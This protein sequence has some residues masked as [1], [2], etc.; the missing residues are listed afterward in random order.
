MFLPRCLGSVT[1]VSERVE[2][3]RHFIKIV[4]L[5]PLVDVKPRDRLDSH[6][7]N[8][9]D[10]AD[11]PDRRLEQIVR[12]IAHNNGAIAVE[13][14]E[15]YDGAADESPSLPVPCTSV[16]RMPAMLCAS[17][18]GSAAKAKPSWARS[19]TTSRTRVPPFT[20]I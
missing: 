15:A 11:P 6:L 3:P 1:F 13:Q 16:E 8:D 10:G 17:C 18:D 20:V 14:L 7:K 2:T 4:N 5:H 9:P 12:R 19:L